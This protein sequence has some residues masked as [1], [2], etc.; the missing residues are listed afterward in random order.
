M[1]YRQ[2]VLAS[3]NDLLLLEIIIHCQRY[4]MKI[5][6]TTLAT[7][8]G[9]KSETNLSIRVS[10]IAVTG[11]VINLLLSY[12]NWQRS[13]HANCRGSPGWLQGLFNGIF[14]IYLMVWMS[15][16]I[17]LKSLNGWHAFVKVCFLWQHVLV[18]MGDVV[19]ASAAVSLCG[20]GAHLVNV[21]VSGN[22]TLL[23][24]DGLPGD[25]EAPEGPEFL[26]LA[27]PYGTFIGGLPGGFHL[28]FICVYWTKLLDKLKCQWK[29]AMITVH[30]CLRVT[31][32]H[33]FSHSPSGTGVQ[34]YSPTL[35]VWQVF[36]CI[37]PI[38]HWNFPTSQLLMNAPLAPKLA[39]LAQ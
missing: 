9:T 37:L 34:V 35:L 19:V 3:W 15:T 10:I 24:V 1:F 22:L 31:P 38:W 29:H 17:I 33:V 25:S 27:A 6:S 21:T 23:E 30:M 16:W 14:K 26:D 4:H 7:P 18:S 28:M 20:S 2:L 5:C 8:R 11:P 13:Y 12:L 39:L 32:C 36:R